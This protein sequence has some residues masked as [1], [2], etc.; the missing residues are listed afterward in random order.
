MRPIHI[1]KVSYC[2]IF[3]GQKYQHWSVYIF[4]LYT[5][6]RLWSK[7]RIDLLIKTDNRKMTDICHEI[8][9]LCPYEFKNRFLERIKSFVRL[10]YICTLMAYKRTYKQLW[11]YINTIIITMNFA[12]ISYEYSNKCLFLF[13]RFLRMCYSSYMF[14]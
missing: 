6:Q 7:G 3:I 5:T 13:F 9:I 2:N 14:S 11:L 10:T 4:F 1:S 12:C 8:N